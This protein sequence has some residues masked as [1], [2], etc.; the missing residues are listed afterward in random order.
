M[1][2]S[3]LTL[4][5]AAT[6]AVPDA[7]VVRT[8]AFGGEGDGHYDSALVDLADGTRLVVRA[9]TDAEADR[10]LRTELRILGSLTDGIRS[11]LPFAVPRVHG[12]STLRDATAG[13]VDFLD[14]YRVR[15]A[16]LPP[17]PA[18]AA[19]GRALAAVHDLPV[20]LA[21]EAG[22]PLDTPERVRGRLVRLVERAGATDRVPAGLIARW[23]A[24]LDDTAL[25]R[26][27]TTV[28]L[29]GSD[30]DRFL[31][32]DDEEG[33]QLTGVLGWEGLAV[34]D[35]ATDLSWLVSAPGAAGAVLDGYA[36][37]TARAVDPLLLDRARLHAELEFAAWLVH[38]V[39]EG[40]E[41]VI[42]DATT[43]LATLADDTR[44]TDLLPPDD[45]HVA[46]AVE[47]LDRVPVA[48]GDP[49]DTSMRTDTYDPAALAAYLADEQSA[50]PGAT[51]PVDLGGWASYTGSD[52]SSPIGEAEDVD[53]A[54]RASR[55]A[56]RR[57]TDGGLTPG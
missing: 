23:R 19:I 45:S 47:L 54:H 48:L 26:F 27:E 15:T 10:A 38:G 51:V 43:L 56:L 57:W 22:L 20:A 41:A 40:D 28:V 39:D 3:P 44:G 9:A 6:A 33:P 13:V 31:F 18:A 30:A 50:E 49:V 52:P 11:V 16:D 34:G 25:W 12:S 36:A 2:R 24:A 37:Q 4:A 42:A 35:P 46:A 53:E 29:G 55:S 32:T 21:R 5:A 17:G 1:P 14:G 8:R 7:T